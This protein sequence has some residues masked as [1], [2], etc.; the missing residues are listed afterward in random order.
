[1]K[2]QECQTRG[3]DMKVAR[4]E[5]YEHQYAYA[6]SP[7]GIK[8]RK[9]YQ[10]KYKGDIEHRLKQREYQ[11]TRMDKLKSD[12]H[13]YAVWREKRALAARLR[14]AENKLKLEL[15]K[16]CIAG[17]RSKIFTQYEMMKINRE[18][19]EAVQAAKVTSCGH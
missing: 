17:I 6:S 19:L 5:I 2:L 3:D 18:L 11:K 8:M 16:N 4:A 10:D 7:R 15:A 9:I 12:P 13:Q 14:R 1:M